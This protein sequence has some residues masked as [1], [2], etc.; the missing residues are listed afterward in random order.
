MVAREKCTSQWIPSVFRKLRQNLSTQI[1]LMAN[2]VRDLITKIKINRMG[3][4][5]L[6]RK[7][8]KEAWLWPCDIVAVICNTQWLAGDGVLTIDR[9]VHVG[10][11]YKVDIIKNLV[12]LIK[13]ASV[14]EDWFI[15]S[16]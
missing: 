2:I 8:S 6:P 4:E 16:R 3:I 1:K 15:A 11:F 5:S 13:P 9:R 12:K 14:L 10:L 7:R